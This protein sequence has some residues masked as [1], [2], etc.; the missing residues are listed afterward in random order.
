[1]AKKSAKS[2]P[3][4]AITSSDVA[5]TSTWDV[6]Q[7]NRRVK[8]VPSALKLYSRLVNDNVKRSAIFAEVRRGKALAGVVEKATVT[9]ASGEVLDA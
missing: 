1:M 4:K 6:V 3:K 2:A 7:D 5:D 8:D 9:N